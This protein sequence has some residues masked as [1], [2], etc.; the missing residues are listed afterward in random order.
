M[1]IFFKGLTQADFFSVKFSGD[2]VQEEKFNIAITN[3]AT[4]TKE[5]LKSNVESMTSKGKKGSIYKKGGEII[6]KKLDKSIGFH[7]NRD[8]SNNVIQRVRFAFERHGV[9][10]EKGVG[11]GYNRQSTDWFNHSID[12][13]VDKLGD[14]AVENA[15][16]FNFDGFGI[17]IK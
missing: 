2:P 6:E 12:A 8:K 16:Q 15:V 17:R 14:I 5:I 10:I 9:Y 4:E 13:Q 11:K 3:W 7:L 1:G